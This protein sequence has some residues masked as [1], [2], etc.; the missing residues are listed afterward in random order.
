MINYCDEYWDDIN[1]AIGSIP[2][3]S[4]LKGKTIMITGAT[5]LIGS[6]VADML[7]YLNNENRSCGSK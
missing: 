3:V 2:M 4:E 7:F 1:K 5:G 6:S